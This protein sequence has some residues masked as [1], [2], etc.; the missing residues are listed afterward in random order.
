ME[1]GPFRVPLLLSAHAG[2]LTP[3][4]I[5]SWRTGAVVVLVECRLER[6]RR[7]ASRGGELAVV[8]AHTEIADRRRRT[9]ERDR[10]QEVVG[11]YDGR[12]DAAVRDIGH[13]QLCPEQLRG[14]TCDGVL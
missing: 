6:D 13:V 9:G 11:Q 4:R 3:E 2:R 12:A 14:Q 8:P 7:R 1:E 5:R 10:L